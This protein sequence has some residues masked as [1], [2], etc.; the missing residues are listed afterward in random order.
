[1]PLLC[2]LIMDLSRCL[3]VCSALPHKKLNSSTC[4]LLLLLVS[5]AGLRAAT[6]GITCCITLAYAAFFM[7]F[8]GLP[9]FLGPCTATCCT[10]SCCTAS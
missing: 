10:D 5:A 3:L 6:P 4:V 2:A 9:L 8:A 7:L 1:V